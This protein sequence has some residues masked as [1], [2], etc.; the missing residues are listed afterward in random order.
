MAQHSAKDTAKNY[1]LQHFLSLFFKTNY[2]LFLYTVFAMLFLKKSAACP[3][4][5]NNNRHN[6]Y[7]I[8]Q[9]FDKVFSQTINRKL[10]PSEKR[11]SGTAANKKIRLFIKTDPQIGFYEQAWYFN[12][13]ILSSFALYCKYLKRNSTSLPQ[14]FIFH[15]KSFF[16]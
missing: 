8:S 4:F 2:T 5:L 16:I 9:A 13:L 15:Q 14:K 6:Y 12:I 10:T 11:P 1:P 3:Q 7:I